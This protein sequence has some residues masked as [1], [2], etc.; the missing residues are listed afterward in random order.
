MALAD[1]RAAVVRRNTSEAHAK[2]I[3]YCRRRRRRRSSR[4]RRV[5]EQVLPRQEGEGGGEGGACSG[6]RGR[7]QCV[8]TQVAAGDAGA[9]GDAAE[10]GQEGPPCGGA[11]LLEEREDGEGVLLNIS[12]YIQSMFSVKV[13]LN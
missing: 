6:Q 13:S 5:S 4:R 12:V 9:G 11:G 10:Q 7:G 8:E 3:L 2:R 1:M